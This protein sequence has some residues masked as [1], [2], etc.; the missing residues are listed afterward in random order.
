MRKAVNYFRLK[1]SV[2]EVRLGSKYISESY[3]ILLLEGDNVH[4]VK[5]V[6]IRSYSG[7]RFFRIF[8]H[9]G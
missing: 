8:P 6:R 3:P 4:C 2:I 5:S 9:L 1:S 7:P